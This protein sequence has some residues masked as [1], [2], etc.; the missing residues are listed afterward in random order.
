MAVLNDHAQAAGKKVMYAFNI[1]GEVDHMRRGHDLVRDL[2][3]TRVMVTLNS[4][5]LSGMLGI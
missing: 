5:D 4:V 3:G 1:T 2:G